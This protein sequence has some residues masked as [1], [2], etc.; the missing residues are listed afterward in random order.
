[1]TVVAILVVC[2]ILAIAFKM[3][4]IFWHS[5]ERLK[6]RFHGLSVSLRVAAKR[7][8]IKNLHYEKA[9]LLFLAD[10]AKSIAFSPLRRN[11]L[12]SHAESDL[13]DAFDALNFAVKYTSLAR[14]T[15]LATIFHT[16]ASYLGYQSPS[17]SGIYAF[18]LFGSLCC[19]A[20]DGAAQYAAACDEAAKRWPKLLPAEVAERKAEREKESERQREEEMKAKDAALARAKEEARRQQEELEQMQRERDEVSYCCVCVGNNNWLVV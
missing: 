20:G 9:S 1:M 11:L 12:N 5:P 19:V 4:N 18:F 14:D 2:V 13:H 7:A 6:H 8:E 10:L 17:Y 3:W 16:A 15:E